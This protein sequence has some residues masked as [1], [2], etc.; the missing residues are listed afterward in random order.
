MTT[1]KVLTVNQVFDILVHWTD[2]R[3][4]AKAFADVV[5]KRKFKDVNGKKVEEDVGDSNDEAKVEAG[6]ELVEDNIVVKEEPE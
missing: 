1:R 6:L 4:W 2:R 3:D 5:P